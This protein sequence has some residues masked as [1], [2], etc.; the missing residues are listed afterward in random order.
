MGPPLFSGV[1]PPLPAVWESTEGS[2]NGA[3]AFQRRKAAEPLLGQD[4]LRAA[5]MGPPRFSGG[6]ARWAVFFDSLGIASM[7]PPRFSGGK[8]NTETPCPECGSASMGPPR[9][10]G[11]KQRKNHFEQ[12]EQLE[13]QWGRRV[14]AAERSLARR[15]VR[16]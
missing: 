1:K 14:S 10:S 6:K 3:A 7:G 13:L 8:A 2:F 9:F 15:K 12:R 11:G 5:S 4:H 16:I